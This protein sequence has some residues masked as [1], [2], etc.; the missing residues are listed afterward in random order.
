MRIISYLMVVFLDKVIDNSFDMIRD[1]NI[2][3][4]KSFCDHDPVYHDGFK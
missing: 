1:V 4:R 3:T 2:T